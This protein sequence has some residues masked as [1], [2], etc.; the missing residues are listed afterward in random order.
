MRYLLFSFVL[1]F[2]AP[3]SYS[4]DAADLVLRD[5]RFY[6]VATPSVVEGSLAVRSGRIVFLGP[7]DEAEELVG[8]RTRVV[9]LDGRAVTPGLIDAHSH[10]LGLGRA[11][12]QV[13]LVATGSYAEVIERVTKAAVSAPAGEWIMGRGWDQ[14]DWEEKAFPSHQLLSGAVPDHPV[15]MT[16]IDGHAA[17]LNEA[18]MRRLG[19]APEIEDPSGGRFLRDDA[20]SLTGVLIDD[21]MD[22]VGGGIPDATGEQLERWIAI[23]AAHCLARG[24]TTVTDMG[25]SQATYEA[26]RNLRD[27]GA[28]PLR[29][30]LFLTDDDELISEWTK[31]GPEIDEDARLLVRGIKLYADGA[32]GS[33]GAA[34]IEPY[35]DDP[36]NVGLL[37]ASK[38]H[39]ESVCRKAL[40]G[41]FQVGIHAIGDRGNLVSLDAIE[42]CFGG[43]KPEVRF[44]VEH[45]QIMRLQDIARLSRLG[46]I[47]SMQPTHATSDMPWAG[48]RVGH[49]RLEGAYAWQRMKAAGAVLALG[50]DF[51]V[52]KADPLLGFYAAVSRQDLEGHPPDGWRSKERLSRSEALRG[53]TLDAAYS[54]FLDHE[55]GSLEVGKRADLVVYSRDPMQI[56]EIEIPEI[57]IDLT[58]VD[59]TIAFERE[60]VE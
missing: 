2:A 40:A 28:L 42:I 60:D 3:P 37:T 55:I 53:F 43:P 9:D 57:D 41:G 35:D 15:W 34:L 31:R 18:A 27:A 48:H 38:A 36:G 4:E 30:S 1:M 12:G 51:P 7:T 25:I 46:V 58:V 16:R 45:A 56:P 33:R 26:Y 24:L 19:I 44:R 14:N 20:G 13:D 17:L 8:P 54:L 50:S 29:A 32:L 59:G 47:A 10:L 52:E 22:L 23:G 6:T 39:L 5:G 21:A 49:E 11:L